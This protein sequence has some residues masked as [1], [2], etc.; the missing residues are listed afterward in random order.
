M[1]NN[2]RIDKENVFRDICNEFFSAIKNKYTI[3]KKMYITGDNHIKEA[4]QACG[5]QVQCFCS[6]LI[7]RV[8]KYYICIYLQSIYTYS[9]MYA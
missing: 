2:K 8:C 4:K 9:Y 7:L 5:R 6:V 1:F 3:S